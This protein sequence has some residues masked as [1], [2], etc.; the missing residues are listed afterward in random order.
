MFKIIK[1][2]G[3]ARA[4]VITTFHGEIKTPGFVPV[5]TLATV[6]ALNPE[7]IRETKTQ[8]IFSNTYHLHLRP[9]EDAVRKIGGLHKF[10]SWDG[11]IITDSGGFQAFSLGFGME[12]GVGKIASIFPGKKKAEPKGEKY[13]HV[14]DDGILFQSHLD[15]TTRILTPEKSIAIQEKLGAD[16]I[17]AF[18]ECTS[19]LSDKKYTREAMER[20]HRWAQR[21]VDAKKSKQAL[22]G[23][24]QGG[25]YKDLRLKSAKAISSM[26]FD[27]LAI[28]GSLGKSKDDMHKVLDWTIPFLPDRFSRHL[29]GIGYV[30]DM[31]ESVERGVDTMD[32]AAITRIARTGSLLLSPKSGGNRK[33][34]W[35]LRITNAQYKTDK[36]P[37]D[38]TCGCYTCK[39]FTRAYLRHLFNA[40]ELLAYSLASIHNVYMANTIMEKIR[41]SILK[42]NFKELKK[43]WLR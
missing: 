11:P 31:F 17:L 8:I 34:A 29:L 6:K 35:R 43:E 41:E 26:E 28:G 32:C 13:A 42:G 5:A 19:P 20:T 1:K 14:S 9:G 27:G 39:N 33:N 37:I 4:G 18:D 12:H 15:K 21:C 22:F 30:D 2:L 3:K 23:I 38:K 10:M 40:N 24:V 25:A 7:Q 36:S 16:I